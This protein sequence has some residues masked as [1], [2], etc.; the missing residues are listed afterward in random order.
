[1][2]DT[3]KAGVFRRAV[4]QMM[5]WLSVSFQFTHPNATRQLIDG[6]VYFDCEDCNSHLALRPIL[7]GLAEGL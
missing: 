5:S 4:N 3:M 2:T 7:V 6:I 1:M